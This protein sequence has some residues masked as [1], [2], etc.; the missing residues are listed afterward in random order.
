VRTVESNQLI[1]ELKLCIGEG[2]EH[3][4]GQKIKVGQKG[5]N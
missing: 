5:E 4:R 3:S 2:G 1:E